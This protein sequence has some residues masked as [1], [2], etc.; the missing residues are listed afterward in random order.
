MDIEKAYEILELKDKTEDLDQ[1]EKQ[2]AK[3]LKKYKFKELNKIED[4]KGRKD[5]SEAYN[6]IM[7]YY[8]MG[9]KD[10][11]VYTKKEL[12]MNFLYYHKLHIIIIALILVFA[13][14]FVHSALTNKEADFSLIVEGLVSLDVEDAQEAIDKL[15]EN[16]G[17][18]QVILITLNPDGDPTGYQGNSM[19]S[20]TLM[21]A[22]EG[23]LYIVDEERYRFLLKDDLFDPLNDYIDEKKIEEDDLIKKEKD[24]SE[25]IG[26]NI[27]KNKVIEKLKI[28]SSS[29][30]YLAKI[31]GKQIT[32]NAKAFLKTLYK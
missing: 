25:I 9:L 18:S 4:N 10:P 31:K 29:D 1:I 3:L 13:G 21:M 28:K 24:S 12:Y 22:K 2:Y 6:F 26:I 11:K 20:T 19:K 15:D 30:L 32:E 8:G 14:T 7:D 23:D 27:T 17:L 5:I 16:I